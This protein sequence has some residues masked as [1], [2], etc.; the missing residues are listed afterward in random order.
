MHRSRKGIVCGAVLGALVA[1]LAFAGGA[2]ATLTG[3]YAK[4]QFCPWTNAEAERCVASVTTGGE[5]VL[6]SKTVPI[7]NPVTLQGGYSAPAGEG[8]EE[9]FSK[10]FAATNGV[11]LSKAG[12]PVPGG[13]L[14]L[15]PPESSPPVVKALVKAATENGLTGV[16]STLELARPASE[17]K[18]NESHLAEALGVSLVLPLKAHLENPVLGSSCYVG[19]STSPILW[20]LTSGET[21]P[22]GPNEPI[23][24]ST[25][26]V[27]FFEGGRI[28]ELENAV[29][30]DNAWSAPSASGCGGLLSAVMDPI[31][32]LASGLPAKAGTNTAIL[33][34]DISETTTFSVNLNNEENPLSEL[35]KRT[36]SPLSKYQERE[37]KNRNMTR[38]CAALLVVALGSLAF[39]GSA[40]AKLT[41][42]F[43]K[44]E[45]CPY[46]TAEVERCLNSLTTGGE[47][48][49]GSK[50]VPIVNPATLQGGYT[51]PATEGPEAG[52]AKFFGATNGVTLSKAAQPVPGGLA[53][54]VNCKEISDF[55]LRISCEVTFENGVTG[56]NSTLELAQPA[57]AIRVSENHLG[58][59]EGVALKMPVRVHLENPFLGGSCYVGS[60]STPLKWE[61]TSGVTNPPL[62]N[63][64][65]T[66]STGQVEFL[67]GAR[68]LRLKDAAIVDNAW[69][70]PA[71]NG[72]G[73]LFSFIIDPIVNASSGLPSAAGKN[74][75]VLKS[76]IM[77]TTS[78][79]LKKNNAENP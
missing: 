3:A 70:A 13:L 32:N 40:G 38:V 53:G 72:C 63:K 34:S 12:Q 25:G 77:T 29:I 36:L 31:I 2:S 41:G 69:S 8:P 42:E 10:F 4:F 7:V 22:P 64:P 18:I 21:S 74:T 17:I 62:P 79:A 6:G 75:A 20:E 23:T 39:V 24:G 30:V 66:G 76:T 46:N 61:L 44:F 78:F 16:N 28:V 33:E 60:S 43:K 11:T 1:V 5:V 52:F 45:F 37:M 26:S 71:A 54:L 9:G 15:L 59:A 27:H 51:E 35:T 14:G 50:K 73:G 55:L 48:V 19:S 68:I 65:I 47:V 67:E 57:S 58:E 49:L 56:V